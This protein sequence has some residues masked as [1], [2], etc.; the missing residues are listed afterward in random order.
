MEAPRQEPNFT[1]S[2]DNAGTA[3]RQQ[4]YELHQPIRNYPKQKTMKRFLKKLEY[5]WDIYFVYFM[6]NGNKTQRYYA[7]LRKKYPEMFTGDK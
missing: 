6:Y 7:Y 2:D 1:G 5:I 4:C 3:G